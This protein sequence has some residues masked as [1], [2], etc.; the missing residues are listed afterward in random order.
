MENK[1]IWQN[2][3]IGYGEESPDQLLANPHNH[4][5]HPKRQQQ[6]LKGSLDTL[7]YIQTV[8]VNKTTGHIVDGHLRVEMALRQPT[9]LGFE[10]LFLK[11]WTWIKIE[12]KR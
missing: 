5:I 9:S 7:G 3:I 1:E 11:F 8:I 10:S 12:S 6:A 4:R 2:R